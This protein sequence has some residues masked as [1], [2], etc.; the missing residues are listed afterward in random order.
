MIRGDEMKKIFGLF[1]FFTVC[2]AMNVFADTGRYHAWRTSETCTAD[3][4]V[5]LATGTI[6]LFDVQVTSSAPSYASFTI[7]KSSMTDFTIVHST[8]IAH[9]ITNRA[10]PVLIF[11]EIIGF[12]MV[13]T[14]TQS[15]C[16]KIRWDWEISPN[17]SQYNKG[18]R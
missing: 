7:F 8:S 15:G 10:D 14:K 2:S 11:D 13:Y 17:P 3:T 1:L 9:N 5:L 18:I 12:G 6:R 4:M 16:I